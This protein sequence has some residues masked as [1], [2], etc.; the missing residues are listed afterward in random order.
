MRNDIRD[1]EKGAY[2][3]SPIEKEVTKDSERGGSQVTHQPQGEVR[4]AD[5]DRDLAG[6][7][8]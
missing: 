5:I 1:G 7:K 4:Q 6:H 8:G 3:L 2:P